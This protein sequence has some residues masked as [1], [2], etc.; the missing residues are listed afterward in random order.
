MFLFGM[1]SCFLMTQKI[2]KNSA[3]SRPCSGRRR[4][5]RCRNIIV[6]GCL[7][8]EKCG[9]SYGWWFR[10]PANQLRLV[11][12]L[13]FYTSQVVGLGFLPS[14]GA[15]KTFRPFG[16]LGTL[17]LC[18]LEDRF[19]HIG[20]N[21]GWVCWSSFGIATP[22]SPVHVLKFDETTCQISF[23]RIECTMP[24]VPVQWQRAEWFL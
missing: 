18:I 15:N 21:A 17:G 7:W 24:N 5:S 1:L 23:K 20:R 8:W 6:S 22:K 10:N 16:G 11:G 2:K 9:R 19:G 13:P 4:I 3:G 14:T 12:Y